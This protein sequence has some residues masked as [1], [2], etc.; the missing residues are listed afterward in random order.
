MIVKY[1]S[2]TSS[3]SWYTFTCILK[4]ALQD[5][6]NNNNNPSRMLLPFVH[7]IYFIYPFEFPPSMEKPSK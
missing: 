6:N 2:K 1:G 3:L 4:W 7:I 5:D